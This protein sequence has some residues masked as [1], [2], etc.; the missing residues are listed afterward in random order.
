MPTPANSLDIT[1]AGLV[2]FDGTSNFTGVT[3]TNH[4]TLVGAASN[5]ITSVVGTTNTVLLG[6]TGADPSFGTVPAGALPGSGAVTLSNGANIT[7]TGSP[8]ALG[9]TATIAVTGPPSPTTYTSNGILYGNGTGAI[10][11]TAQGAAN[12]VLLGN[13]GIP[14]FGAVP[15]AALSGSGAITISSGTN[16]NITGSPVSLGGTATVNVAGPITPTTYTI[17]GVLVGNSTSAINATAA[18]STG[19]VLQGNTGADPTYSTATY[20]STST[21]NQILYSSSN[22]VIAGLSTANNGVLIT[23]AAGVPSYLANGTTGQVLTATTGSPPT[24]TSTGAG[25]VTS[26]SGTP[27]RITSTGGATP[28]IDIAANYVGQTSLTTLGTVTTGTWNGTTITVPNGGTGVTSLTANG[29]VIGQGTG[30]VTVTAVGTAGQVL[31]S[32]GAGNDPTFQAITAP[33]I[34]SSASTSFTYVDDM[35]WGG[36]GAV[37]NGTLF[38]PWQLSISGGSAVIQPQASIVTFANHPGQIQLN[39]GASGSGYAD[40]NMFGTSGFGNSSPFYIG[41]GILTF[42]YYFY[43]PFLSNA[44]GRFIVRCGMYDAT[45]GADPANGIWVKYSDNLNSGNWTYN[46]SKSST[47]TNVNSSTA[48]AVG[49]QV[50]RI[51]VNANATS[52]SFEAGNKTSTLV[53]LGSAITT[54]IPTNNNDLSPFF[55]IIATAGSGTANIFPDLFTGSIAYTNAR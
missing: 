12:T 2:K 43:L 39:T 10:L 29:V 46:C 53:T 41:A 6:N 33:S 5:G 49:W 23:S 8:L 4:A 45:P 1:A 19:Q 28:V 22:N 55:S 27:N 44:P 7:V 42:T 52:V 9:G 47:A 34:I 48:V 51:V 38:G 50:I 13:G 17:H 54:N 30:N 37:S 35:I 36:R 21:I 3:V 32:N 20:P 18:G 14:S 24:W 11:V 26:V 15:N 40:L 25:T 16:I 31:T